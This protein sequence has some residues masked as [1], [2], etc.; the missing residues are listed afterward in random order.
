MAVYNLKENP[1]QKIFG[2]PGNE[3][4][5]IILP[6]NTQRFSILNNTTNDIFFRFDDGEVSLSSNE[7]YKL[8]DLVMAFTD[9]YSKS[10][11]QKIKI[12]SNT[13]SSITLFNI[14]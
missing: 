1:K 10:E 6:A 11:I 7:C 13:L 8:S 12:M 5:E 9:L 2:I 4:C 14:C 3:K